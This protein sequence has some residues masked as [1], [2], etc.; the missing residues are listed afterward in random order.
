V[1]GILYNTNPINGLGTTYTGTA[2]HV[3]ALKAI[4][5]DGQESS[6]K[7]AVVYSSSP[8]PV[9]SSTP[10]PVPSS[11]P[12]PVPSSTPTPE[13]TTTPSPAPTTSPS[14]I[15]VD[16]IN[17]CATAICSC[18]SQL[19]PVLNQIDQDTNGII[20]AIT[21]QVTPLLQ[22]ITNQL[23][24][25]LQLSE[26]IE[27]VLTE[28]KGEFQNANDYPIKTTT[29]Y[30]PIQLSDNKPLMQDTVF[31]DSTTY[32]TDQGDDIKPSAFPTA[33]DPVAWKDLQGN[34]LN[35]QTPIIKDIPISSQPVLTT[36][37]VLSPSPIISNAPILPRASPMIRETPLPQETTLYALRWKSSDY[38]N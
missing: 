30:P 31:T 17:N 11:T 10:T 22:T 35:E 18:I 2:D 3:F 21:D 37:P 32:F 8:T 13:P 26:D 36:S 20:S 19:L 24:Q 38:S 27:N 29:D 14:P 28:F 7:T 25:Q 34:V 1:D 4:N 23:T 16:D 12:T 5:T 6:P 9:P 33:P 15:T